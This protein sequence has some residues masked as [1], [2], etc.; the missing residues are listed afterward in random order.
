MPA[1][2]PLAALS[3]NS[4]PQATTHMSPSTH[5]HMN[6]PRAWC[7]VQARPSLLDI[8]IWHCAVPCCA[9]LYN[10]HTMFSASLGQRATAG[11]ARHNP[12]GCAEQHR[13][14]FHEILPAPGTKRAGSDAISGGACLIRLNAPARRQSQTSASPTSWA[15]CAT[16]QDHGMHHQGRPILMA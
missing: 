11:A 6:D 2:I 16:L 10:W 8:A 14:M 12:T 1:A 9:V 5:E 15:I 7:C 13:T 3:C 4:Q